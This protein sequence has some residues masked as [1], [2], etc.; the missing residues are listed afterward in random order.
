MVIRKRKGRR[1]YQLD[2]GV[3]NGKRYQRQFDTRREAEEHERELKARVRKLGTAALEMSPADVRAWR[4]AQDILRPFGLSIVEA[5]RVAAA[6]ARRPADPI[7]LRDL[8]ERCLVDKQLQGLRPRYVSQLK[9]CYASLLASGLENVM[10]HQVTEEAISKWLRSNGWAPKT[11]NNYL[12]DVRTLFLY[13]I[14]NGFLFENPAVGIKRV[15]VG[16]VEEIEILGVDECRVLLERCAAPDCVDLMGYLVLGLFCGIRPDEMRDA[17]KG[18]MG[19][20]QVSLEDGTAVV[21][22]GKS[23]TRRRRVVEIPENGVEWLG[24]M[25][26]ARPFIPVNFDRRWKGLRAECGWATPVARKGMA[27]V[28]P[29][30]GSWSKWP[31]DVLRHT[32]ASMHY[33]FFQ[34]EGKT[35]AM[36]GHADNDVLFTNYRALVTQAEAARFYEL[37]PV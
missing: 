20:E 36:L 6:R 4:E 3:I 7:V 28:V 27:G 11:Q 17:Q 26:R 29:L 9:C 15:A 18:R 13:G 33:A 19:W 22:A 16:N 1:G 10:A 24:L 12:Q 23:K 30:K 8:V 5:A 31:H 37:R 14:E 21:L 25:D 35:K 2:A 34:N 32:A